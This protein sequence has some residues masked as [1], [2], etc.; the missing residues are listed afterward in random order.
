V[1]GISALWLSAHPVGGIAEATATILFGCLFLFCLARAW[2]HIRKRRVQLHR[3]WVIR[4]VAIALGAAT[5]R[6][7][8]AV[9]FATSR[10]TGCVFRGKPNSI[11]G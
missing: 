4:M 2:W 9:F 6:P 3:E 11:P 5:T 10:V 8:I 1:I 7:I